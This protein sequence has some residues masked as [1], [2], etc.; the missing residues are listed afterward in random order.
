MIKKVKTKEYSR[1]Y[2]RVAALL[3]AVLGII[4]PFIGIYLLWSIPSDIGFISF[5]I[6]L[7]S[8]LLLQFFF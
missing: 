1:Y 3:L 6:F 2:Y 4:S 5:L 7:N 8:F